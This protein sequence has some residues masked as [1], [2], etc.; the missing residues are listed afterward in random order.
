VP[1]TT[2]ELLARFIGHELI[3]AMSRRNVTLPHKLKIGVDENNGQWGY[4]EIDSSDSKS[5]G[6]IM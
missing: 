4:C 6:R 2:T 3:E 5:A 1:N